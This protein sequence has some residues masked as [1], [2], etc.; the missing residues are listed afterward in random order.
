L[1]TRVLDDAFLFLCPFEKL[2]EF[3]ASDAWN[4]AEADP[5]SLLASDA[6][7]ESFQLQQIAQRRTAQ[8]SPVQLQATQTFSDARECVLRTVGL[9]AW[10]VHDALQPDEVLPDLG[11][12]ASSRHFRSRAQPQ[13]Q[14][15]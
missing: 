9:D 14:H 15:A 11:R 13:A 10:P 12:D 3:L 2:I 7:N 5:Q 6:D 1:H 8:D 4:V